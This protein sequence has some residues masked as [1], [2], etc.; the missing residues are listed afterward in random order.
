MEKFWTNQQEHVLK[1]IDK[2]FRGKGGLV[3]WKKAYAFNPEW[4][5]ALSDLNDYGKR[6]CL[7]SIRRAQGK[8]KLSTDRRE[9]GSHGYR[10][11]PNVDEELR[12][13]RNEVEKA[14]LAVRMAAQVWHRERRNLTNARY[15]LNRLQ[16]LNS[17]RKSP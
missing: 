16:Y 4:R 1:Q 3:S 9:K 12:Q 5:R 2:R 8:K 11:H 15:R 6:Q 17:N 13:A 10:S 14:S 7:R